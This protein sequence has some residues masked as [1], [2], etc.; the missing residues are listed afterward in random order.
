[1]CGNWCGLRQYHSSIRRKSLPAF[2]SKPVAGVAVSMIL[3][4]ASII[5]NAAT[6]YVMHFDANGISGAPTDPK[7]THIKN[8]GNLFMYDAPWI[9]FPPYV[10][11]ILLGYLMQQKSRIKIPKVRNFKK[12]IFK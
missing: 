12:V 3:I 1:M 2:S 5:A 4:G 7:R 8:A 6:V 11:G 10:I 9:R